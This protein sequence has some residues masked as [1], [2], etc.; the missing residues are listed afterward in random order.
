ML[1][2]F[3]QAGGDLDSDPALGEKLY[4]TAMTYLWETDYQANVIE[5]HNGMVC[6]KQP[7][8]AIF[9]LS[10]TVDML[11]GVPRSASVSGLNIDV[12]RVIYSPISKKGDSVAEL[13]FMNDG[14]ITGSNTQHGIIEQVYRVGAWRA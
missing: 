8:E 13:N 1:K 7:G 3:I 4:L 5:N 11:F 2:D 14:G 10:L 9:S 12:D 6:L